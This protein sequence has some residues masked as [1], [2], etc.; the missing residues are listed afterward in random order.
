[1]TSTTVGNPGE[2]RYLTTSNTALATLQTQ[3]KGNLASF[4][5]VDSLFVNNNGLQVATNGSTAT[6]GT[7]YVGTSDQFGTAGKPGKQV[8]WGCLGQ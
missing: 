7:S 3:T 2:I 1:M 6:A 5:A 8:H 4:A